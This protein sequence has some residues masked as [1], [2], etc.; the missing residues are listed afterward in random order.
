MGRENDGTKL[1]KIQ[2]IITKEKLNIDDVVYIGDTYSDVILCE[3]LKIK[4][5]LSNYG[6]SDGSLIQSSNILMKANNIKEIAKFI[7]NN[8]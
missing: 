1:T 2:D 4:I 5:I 8:L 7:K 6:Y 3:K